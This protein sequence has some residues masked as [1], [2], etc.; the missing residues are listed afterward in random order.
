MLKLTDFDGQQ[1]LKLLAELVEFAF[2]EGI[3][4]CQLKIRVK[5]DTFSGPFSPGLCNSHTLE[6][7]SIMMVMASSKV[8][9]YLVKIACSEKA[10]HK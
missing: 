8:I 7:S 6:I 4:K 9:N 1:L 2:M 3:E 5:T 10:W